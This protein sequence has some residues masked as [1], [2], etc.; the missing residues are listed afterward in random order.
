MMLTLKRHPQ[1]KSG[2]DEYLR[3]DL[4]YPCLGVAVCRFASEHLEGEYP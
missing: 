4:W 3:R 1:E 2:G